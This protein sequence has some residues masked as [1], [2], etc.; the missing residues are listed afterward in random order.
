MTDKYDLEK[1][2]LLPDEFKTVQPSELA[3]KIVRLITAE[4]ADGG[5]SDQPVL[6]SPEGLALDLMT[7][8]SAMLLMFR[9]SAV[10][11]TGED[12]PIMERALMAAKLQSLAC[13]AIQQ[14][15]GGP[16]R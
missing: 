10:K 11:M 16:L 15:L 7:A 8:L 14:G 1:L 13:A 5:A 9:E 2:G 12:I 3:S 6:A 4:L